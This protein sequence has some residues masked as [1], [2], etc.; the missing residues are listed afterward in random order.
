[1]TE[2]IDVN[3]TIGMGKQPDGYTVWVNG[4]NRCRIRISGLIEEQAKSLRD[5]LLDIALNMIETPG[6]TEFTGEIADMD[7]PKCGSADFYKIVNVE[8]FICKDC[9]Y[10]ES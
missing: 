2:E 3:S 7:C 8:V 9:G 4:P 5:G 1:M 10:H 6:E